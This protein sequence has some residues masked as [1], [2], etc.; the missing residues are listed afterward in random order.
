MAH[1]LHGLSDQSA[2][3]LVAGGDRAHAGDVVRAV[4]LLAV[5]LHGLDGGSGRLGDALL[6]DHGVGAGGQVLQALVDDGL[7]QQ[8]GGGGAIAGHIVGLG[9]DLLHQL[10]THVLKGVLQLDLLGDGDAVVG[11]QGSAEL[12][13]QHHVAALGAHGDLYSVGQLVHALF[14]SLAG[15]FAV[16]NDLSHN[17]L[18]PI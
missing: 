16:A 9:G 3:G 7:S 1:L 12:L 13:I 10:G 14:Q 5:G 17:T 8:G 18:P 15:L 6:H 11:D 2:D 4:D